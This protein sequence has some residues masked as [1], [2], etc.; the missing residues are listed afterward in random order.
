MK[1]PIY[2]RRGRRAR[3]TIDNVTTVVG[4]VGG[5]R[6]SK[7]PWRFFSTLFAKVVVTDLP[8]LRARQ[9]RVDIACVLNEIIDCFFGARQYCGIC[10]L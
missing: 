9:N 2:N 7:R 4:V 1:I 6:C 3:K 8:S 5:N 10:K